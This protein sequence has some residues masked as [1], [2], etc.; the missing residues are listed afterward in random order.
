M[1]S[2][3]PHA[4]THIPCRSRAFSLLED[5]AAVSWKSMKLLQKHQNQKGAKM[6]KSEVPE[7]ELAVGLQECHG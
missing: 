5:S 1:W 6:P 4:H 7:Q 3:V 2:D